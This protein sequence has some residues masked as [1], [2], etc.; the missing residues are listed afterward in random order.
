MIRV[1]AHADRAAILDADEHSATDRAI[2]AG[3]GHPA[4]G[5]LLRGSVAVLGI[6]AVGI[7]LRENV[8]AEFS[9][10]GSCGLSCAAR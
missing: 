1:A 2:S 5:N 9:L 7:L 6:V 3:R 4:I 10:A 8:E